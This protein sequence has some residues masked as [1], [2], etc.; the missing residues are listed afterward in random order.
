MLALLAILIDCQP[1]RMRVVNILMACVCV[2]AGNDIHAQLA[3][4][5]RYI[6]KGI[7]IPQPL[8]AVVQGNLGGVEGDA[9][10]RI[11]NCGIS[12]DSMEIVQPELHVVI[13]GIVFD[14]A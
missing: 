6:A 4:A 1:V 9:P 11:Q 5:V 12:M 13:A 8:A 14:E 10:A 3:A 2:G 7:H